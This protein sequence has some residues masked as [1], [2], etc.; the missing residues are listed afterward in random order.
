MAS[1]R[2][3]SEAVVESFWTTVYSDDAE[4]HSGTKPNGIPG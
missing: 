1:Q 2:D 3:G 4:R